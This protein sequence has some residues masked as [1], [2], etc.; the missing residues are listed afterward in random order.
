V[1]TR[2]AADVE[3]VGIWEAQRIAVGHLHRQRDRF[4]GLDEEPSI[5]SVLGASTPLRSPV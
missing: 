2:F 3:R 1:A 4:A 5:A